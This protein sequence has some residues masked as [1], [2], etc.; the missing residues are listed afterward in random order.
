VLAVVP[1]VGSIEVNTVLQTLPQPLKD[2]ITSYEGGAAKFLSDTFP[3]DISCEG[4]MLRRLNGAAKPRISAPPPPPSNTLKRSPCGTELHRGYRTPAEVLDVMVDYVPTQFIDIRRLMDVIPPDVMQMT[5]SLKFDAFLKKYRFYFEVRS[6]NGQ[7]EVRLRPDVSHPRRGSADQRLAGG[8]SGSSA[9]IRKPPRNSE[10]NLIHFIAPKIPKSFEPLGEVLQKIAP[11]VS[12][13]A[14][15]DP[16]LGVVGLLEKYPEYFQLRNGAIRIRPFA[17][18]PNSTDDL[19]LATSPLPSVLQK[20]IHALPDA[21]VAFGDPEKSCKDAAS[22]YALLTDTE[23]QA[24][25]ETF[26]SFSK[27]LRMHGRVVVVSPDAT[28]VRRFVPENEPCADTL[29]KQQLVADSLDPLDPILQIPTQM[30]NVADSEWAVKELYDALPLTQA[31]ELD[32]LLDLVPSSVKQS[33]PREHLDE[34]LSMYTEYFACWKYPDNE[35]ILVVQRAKLATPDFEDAEIVR[36]VSPLIPQGGIAVDAL[37]RRVPLP[38]QRYF[39]RHG[40]RTVLGRLSKYFMVV[41]DKV[42]RIG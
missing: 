28:R 42:L 38:L 13:H 34:H 32:E 10:A 14:A 26:K 15:F 40:L 27:F 35:T 36:M 23:K 7:V 16:R 30:E 39:Y 31:V 2:Q 9:R 25:K 24:L 33:L 17:S 41:K 21:E 22:I 37:R 3:K 18:A 11:V 1:V 4:T 8:A 29:A 20:V 5:G 12:K 19:D 6:A